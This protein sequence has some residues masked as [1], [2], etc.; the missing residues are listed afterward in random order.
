MTLVSFLITL[1][2]IGV[3]WYLVYKYVPMPAV[4]KTVLNVAAV[5]IAILLLLSLFKIMPLPFDLK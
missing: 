2:V 1:C 3:I 4:F 5:A